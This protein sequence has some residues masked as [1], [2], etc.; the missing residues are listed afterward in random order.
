MTHAYF[1][2]QHFHVCSSADPPTILISP[3]SGSASLLARGA[4]AAATSA[5]GQAG[6]RSAGCCRYPILWVQSHLHPTLWRAMSD[7]LRFHWLSF[8]PSISFSVFFLPC[9]SILFFFVSFFHFFLASISLFLFFRHSLSHRLCHLLCSLSLFFSLLHF[10]SHFFFNFLSN[11]SQNPLPLL[12]PG[13]RRWNVLLPRFM[14]GLKFQ[15]LEETSKQRPTEKGNIVTDQMTSWPRFLCFFIAW[16][17]WLHPF[18]FFF[19]FFLEASSLIIEKERLKL[20]L[21]SD[22]SV[23]DFCSFPL[24]GQTCQD[25]VGFDVYVF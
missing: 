15:Y 19:F 1:H 8:F 25:Y 14:F 22:Y 11:T 10:Y 2:F 20:T 23:F 5:G 7:L 13:L 21:I 3:G 16:W 17:W 24:E 9:Y 6:D 18:F 4:A 12:R